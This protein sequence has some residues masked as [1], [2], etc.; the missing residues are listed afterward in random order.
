MSKHDM[1][2]VMA[3]GAGIVLV[4]II[5]VAILVATLGDSV[6]ADEKKPAAGDEKVITT[7]SGLKYVETKIGTGKEAKDGSS[8][9]VHYTGTFTDGK[10]F[11]S[12]LDRGEPYPVVIGKSRVI[13]G[14]HEGLKGM[15]AGGKRKI[16]VP[17][18]LAYGKRG[19]DGIPPDSTLIFSNCP[20]NS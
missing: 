7:D 9:K 6:V 3:A 11:D 16:I 2:K 20:G 12:S 5:A 4:A 10:K 19:R 1:S 17:P 13:Q 18:E 8:V 15:K 14:W